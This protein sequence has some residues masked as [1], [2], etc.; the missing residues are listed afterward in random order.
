MAKTLKNNQTR[1]IKRFS[2]NNRKEM[3]AIIDM[4]RSGDWFYIPKSEWKALRPPPV[5]KKTKKT[6]DK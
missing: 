5:E 3:F 1:E 2:E 6:K 4:V